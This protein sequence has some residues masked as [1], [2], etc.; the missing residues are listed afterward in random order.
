MTEM[1]CTIF[2]NKQTIVGFHFLKSVKPLYHS[3]L[4]LFR[5]KAQLVHIL[6]EEKYRLV[7]TMMSRCVKASV[8]RNQTG[9][10]LASG[11]G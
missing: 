2:Q 4:E 5:S 9:K 11:Q 6:Y 3:F 8:Y 10:G 7:Y 1:L